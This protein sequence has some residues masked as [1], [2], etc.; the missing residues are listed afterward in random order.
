MI[1]RVERVI[2]GKA[3]TLEAG[4]IAGNSDGAVTVRYGDT[5]VLVAA[6]MSKE[7]RQ[8]TDFFPSP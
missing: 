8:G 4:K 3:M 7:P 2:G 5:M 1:H 6:N